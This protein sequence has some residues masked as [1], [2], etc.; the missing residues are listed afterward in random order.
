MSTIVTIQSTDLITD[1]RADINNNFSLLNSEKLE[2]SVLS[3]DTTLSE[4]SDAKVA[5]QKAVKAYITSFL[6]PVSL[7][8]PVGSI[9]LSVVSTN[10]GTLFGVGTWVAWGTGRVPVG[11]D[12][13]QTEFDTVE[14]TG[15]EKTHTLTIPEIPSHTH[16]DSTASATTGS[17]TALT[18][19]A[20]ST[21]TSAT[22]TTGDATGG[23]N[24]H[25]NL[26][27]YITCYMWKRTA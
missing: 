5:T 13:G 14:K 16:T 27:P 22:K 4:N 15:G 18:T 17:E 20:I 24:A 11:I 3:T 2:T 9:Y 12:V 23:G 25:N 21:D 8:Y 19:S 10:P 6:N 1:S 26:Q 7:V